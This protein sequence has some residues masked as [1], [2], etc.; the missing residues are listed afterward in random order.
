MAEHESEPTPAN[1]P[2]A[3]ESDSGQILQWQT[4]G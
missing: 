2:A 3:F 1:Q 4:V